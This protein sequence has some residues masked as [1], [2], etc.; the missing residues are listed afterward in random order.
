MLLLFGI[1][2]YVWMKWRTRQKPDEAEVDL[3][4]VILS[5][6]MKPLRPPHDGDRVTPVGLGME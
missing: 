2:V 3:D 6:A 1:P 5:S 4:R